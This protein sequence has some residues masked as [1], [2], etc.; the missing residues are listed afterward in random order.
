VGDRF[1]A[2]NSLGRIALLLI[3]ALIFV[4][5]GLWLAGLFGPSPKPG[6]EWI[7]WVTA[8]FSG[9][10]GLVLASR[11]FDREDWLVIDRNGIRWRQWSEATIPW[12]AIRSWSQYSVRRQKFLCLELKDPS[13]FPGSGSGAWL[14]GINKAIGFGDIA[15]SVVG[16]DRKFDE[17]A[18]AVR[19]YAPPER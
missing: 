6:R 19:R 12:S 9:L 13:Q 10:A 14:R 4:A 7:G 8:L 16:T 15:L 11:L 5:G 18:E 2:R 1:V 17:L 3:G